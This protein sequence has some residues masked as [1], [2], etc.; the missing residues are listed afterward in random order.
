MNK[1][2]R[3]EMIFRAFHNPF[4][5]NILRLGVRAAVPKSR[6]GVGLVCVN[7]E[8]QI[9][10]LKHV[11]HP[12]SPWGL[13]GGWLE[14]GEDPQSCALRE[15]E[16]EIGLSAA[17]GPVIYVSREPYPD[18]VGIAFLARLEPGTMKL[19]SEIMEAKYFLKEELPRPLTPFTLSVVDAWQTAKE[20]LRQME[21]IINE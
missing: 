10:L 15:L 13:P 17:I 8:D 5:I 3:K 1:N 4:L 14:K 9:L 19:S 11:Y 20:K 2:Q 6:I 21:Y 16:E 7:G 12:N 18:H